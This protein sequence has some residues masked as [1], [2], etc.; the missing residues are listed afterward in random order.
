MI[1][2]NS[3]KKEALE[4]ETAIFRKEPG[5]LARGEVGALLPHNAI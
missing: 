1:W 4:A 5:A 3:R 2:I